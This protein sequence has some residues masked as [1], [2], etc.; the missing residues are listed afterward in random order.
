MI[1]EDSVVFFEEVTPGWHH[2]SFLVLEEGTAEL[3]KLVGTN[4]VIGKGLL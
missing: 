4:V 1:H 2:S 3:P